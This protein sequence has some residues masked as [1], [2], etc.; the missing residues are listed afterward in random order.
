MNDSSFLNSNQVLKG[1]FKTLTDKG[2]SKVF[3]YKHIEKED[4]D[5]LIETGVIG[6]HNPKSL[7]ILEYLV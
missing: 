6:I 7:Q 4:I 2:L 1:M 5:K 3:H